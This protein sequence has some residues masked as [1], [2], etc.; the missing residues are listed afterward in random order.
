[1]S[2]K[3]ANECILV[4]IRQ[5]V[6]DLK[7]IY[8]LNEVGARIWEL[9]DGIRKAKAIKDIIIQ[10]FEVTSEKAEMDLKEYLQHLVEINAID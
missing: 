3:I 5:K 10:E 1:M 2:R 4:P 8:T 6:A 9:I 7:S